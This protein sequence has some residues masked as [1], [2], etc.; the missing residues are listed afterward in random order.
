MMEIAQCYLYL[1]SKWI[2]GSACRADGAQGQTV[3]RVCRYCSRDG[4]NDPEVEAP[5]LR[6]N[7]YRDGVSE[8]TKTTSAESWDEMLWYRK[9]G[10]RVGCNVTLVSDS[11]RCLIE[12]MLETHTKIVRKPIEDR[13]SRREVPMS[14]FEVTVV[15]KAGSK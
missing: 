15:S 1:R 3:P 13:S 12:C 14:N 6:I 7:K 9:T 8:R 11:H 2:L 5:A 4:L 10:Q